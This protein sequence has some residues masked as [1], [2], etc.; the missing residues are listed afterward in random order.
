MCI[1]QSLGR[2]TE[3]LRC[4]VM[5]DDPLTQSDAERMAWLRGLIRELAKII[6]IIV[7]TFHVPPGRLSPER[8]TETRQEGQQDPTRSFV[9]L[10]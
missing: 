10:A 3:Q 4:A 7:F 5:L 2:A 6:Q 1:G 9:R 8:G